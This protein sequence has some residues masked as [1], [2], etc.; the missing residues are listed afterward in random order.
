MHSM[1]VIILGANTLYINFCLFRQVSMAS[2]GLYSFT[3]L[4]SFVFSCRISLRKTIHSS[5]VFHEGIWWHVK[6]S[7]DILTTL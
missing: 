1:G 6:S 3:I 7:G 2:K 4:Y 5:S